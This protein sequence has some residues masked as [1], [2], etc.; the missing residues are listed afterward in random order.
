MRELKN[1]L[2]SAAIT[3]PGGVIRES[4][5][6]ASLRSGGGAGAATERGTGAATL[7]EAERETI[8]RALKRHRGN[9]THAARSLNIGVRTLQRKIRSYGL[10]APA[11]SG[12]PR[13]AQRSTV[14][15]SPGLSRNATA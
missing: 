6:P 14:T 8:R 15:P 2:E 11:P 1:V 7:A 4:D 5:L 12:R 9:R 10:K 3:R 13:G